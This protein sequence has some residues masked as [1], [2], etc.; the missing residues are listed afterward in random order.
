MDAILELLQGS[1]GKNLVEGASQQLGLDKKTT[2]TAVAA[3]VPL[4]LGALKNNASSQEGASGLLGALNNPRHSGGSVLDNLGSI[5]GGSGIDQDVMDDGEKIL[6][7]MFR[8]QQN[9]AAGALSKTS[10]I[11]MDKAMSL[12]KVAAP[13][14]MAYLGRKTQQKHVNSQSGLE[15]LLGG[16]LGGQQEAQQKAAFQLQDFDN[17]DSSIDDIAGMIMGSGSSQGLGGLVGGF[18]KNF[19]K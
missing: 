1:V 16:L 10:G 13:L 2:S 5:L 9:N 12:M 4:L 3:A 18:L 11:D 7:H 14:V 15:G 6:G 19:S 17:N 8:G